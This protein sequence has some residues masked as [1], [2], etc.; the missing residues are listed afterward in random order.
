MKYI[1]FSGI[2][3]KLPKKE[4]VEICDFSLPKI[5]H[6]R[7]FNN[8][9]LHVA[10]EKEYAKAGTDG[11][12]FPT[13]PERNPRDFFMWIRASKNNAKQIAT[14]HHELVHLKQYAKNEICPMTATAKAPHLKKLQIGKVLNYY[15][16]PT[17][18][19]AFGR[20]RGMTNLYIEHWTANH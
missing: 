17:E 12:I 11:Y 9:V 20:S 8:I 16:D 4:I 2:N 18:I 19:E 13:Y 14:L 1:R 5:L 3:I 15:N 6:C 10:F 7:I